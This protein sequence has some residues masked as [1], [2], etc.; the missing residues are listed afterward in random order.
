[1]LQRLKIAI[2]LILIVALPF[3]LPGRLGA[4]CFVLMAMA[5]LLL[6]CYEVFA[7]M[8][9][10]GG[11]THRLF[12]ILFAWALLLL[13][14]ADSSLP[15]RMSTSLEII[16]TVLFIIVSFALVFIH[17]PTIQRV[18]ALFITLGITLYVCWSLLFVAKL[19]FMHNGRLLLVYMLA[20]TKMADVGAYIC[21]SLTA[22]MPAGN[23]KLAKTL[24]PKKSWEGLVGG[25]LFS[26]ATAAALFF[27]PGM[28][29]LGNGLH[30]KLW[31]A[32]IF[33][34]LA[35]LLGLLGDLA[36]SC[37][38]RAANAKDSG[39]IPNIGGILDVLDS[40]MPVAPLFYAFLV[41]RIAA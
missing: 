1:M 39:K 36:E 38:K 41:M 34:I 28:L 16:I 4:V 9:I 5:M 30:L 23:H 18:N 24:S 31:E 25:T 15:A 32:I 27:I 26:T 12:T 3:V 19:Y 17:G 8:N 7:M 11:R 6:A 2:P 40:L 37:V 35:S 21:G 10:A 14:A 33:G 20:V 22:S 29:S 13:T